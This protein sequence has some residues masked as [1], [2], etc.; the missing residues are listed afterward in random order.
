MQFIASMLGSLGVQGAVQVMHANIPMEFQ[1]AAHEW[2]ILLNF[3]TVLCVSV[4][5]LS[6]LGGKLKSWCLCGLAAS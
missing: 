4:G 3:V 6:R 1:G 2:H 5:N